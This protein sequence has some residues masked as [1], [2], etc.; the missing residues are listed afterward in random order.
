MKYKEE[1]QVINTVKEFLRFRA[2]PSNRHYANYNEI[3]NHMGRF[4][5]TD[6]V[7]S[8]IALFSVE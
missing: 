8:L 4:E 5:F 7:P 1:F 3:R 6:V 2:N